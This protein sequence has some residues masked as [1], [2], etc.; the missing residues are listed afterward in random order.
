MPE[1]VVAKLAQSR[2]REVLL[3]RLQFLKADDVGLCFAKPAQEHL[4]PAIDAV[5]V[6]G[7]NLH[8]DN[9]CAFEEGKLTGAARM[10]EA[11]ASLVATATAGQSVW[12]IWARA[13]SAACCEA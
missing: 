3:Q 1:G 6:I 7:G 10:R 4:Q 2:G 8:D 13:H 11:Y 12:N 9:L 5:D